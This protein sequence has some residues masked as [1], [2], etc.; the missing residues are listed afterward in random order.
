MWPPSCAVSPGVAAGHTHRTDH[1]VTECVRCPWGQAG[2]SRS[3]FPSNVGADC[4]TQLLAGKMWKPPPQPPPARAGI[5]YRTRDLPVLSRSFRPLCAH[6]EHARPAVTLPPGSRRWLCP[7]QPVNI[8]FLG[9][10]CSQ[11]ASTS[12]AGSAVSARDTGPAAPSPDR[13]Q[14]H[15]QL[16]PDF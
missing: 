15:R 1:S 6:P 16:R 9:C 5:S 13:L 4:N 3:N 12:P 8:G 14:G 2:S 10:G 11:H 7:S